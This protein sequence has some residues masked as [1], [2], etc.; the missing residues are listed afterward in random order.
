MATEA[1]A[2]ARV[3]ARLTAKGVLE[4]AIEIPDLISLIPDALRRL[5]Y[6]LA[7]LEPENPRRQMLEEATTVTLSSGVGDLTTLEAANFLPDTIDRGKIRHAD[8]EYPLQDLVD[9]LQLKWDW[10]FD[11]IYFVISGNKIKTRNTDG[12]LDTLTG[13]LTVTAVKIPTLAGLKTQLETDFL[14]E[15]EE[16]ALPA[17]KKK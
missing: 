4:T 13:N 2:A 12:A 8:S 3:F 10:P 5:A 9:E 15:M 11:F 14:D 17:V 16:L 7:M 6:R 1:W